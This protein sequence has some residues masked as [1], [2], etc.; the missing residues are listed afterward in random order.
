[1]TPSSSNS[2]ELSRREALRLSLIGSAAFLVPSLASEASEASPDTPKGPLIPYAPFELNPKVQEMLLKIPNPVLLYDLG[3]VERCYQDYLKA[4][5]AVDVHYAVKCAPNPRVMSRLVR[6]GSGFDVASRAELDLA[7]EA[8]ADPKKCIYSNTCKYP[9]DVRYAR[10]KGVEAFLADSEYEVK[11]QA[12][13]APGSKLYVRLLVNNP[14]A[15]H[16]LGDKFGTTPEKAKELLRLGKKL[17]LVPYGTHFHVGTQCYSA[18][19]W[20]QPARQAAGIFR[21]LKKEGITLELFDIGGGFPVQYLGAK[22]P[23]NREI[24]SL[25]RGVLKE[26][27]GDFPLTLAVEPGRG[28]VGSAALMSTRVMLRADRPDAEWLH[29]D[30]GIY[31]GLSDAPDGIRYPIVAVNR[32]GSPTPYTLC[33]PTCDSADTIS[34]N[35]QLPGDIVPGDL[36]VLNKAGAY[37][38]CLFSH[39]NG[40]K[41]PE[42]KYLDDIV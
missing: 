39:F 25:V 28:L 9:D 14:D 23:T 36:L 13:C 32:S 27:L 42:I 22:V 8:G 31:H 37:A 3:E 34:K 17:G 16:P 12:E 35:Q 26:E 20:E 2:Q 1:M 33:G 18:K 4:D 19:A 24:I 15:A 40:I 30:V 5:A 29:L 21:D 38:E 7:L 10:E 11:M 41:P 6:S